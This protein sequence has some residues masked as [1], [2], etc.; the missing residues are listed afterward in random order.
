M[1]GIARTAVVS[2]TSWSYTLQA[3]DLTAMGQGPQTL[4]VTQTDAAGNTI[5][6]VIEDASRYL[7][8]GDARDGDPDQPDLLKVA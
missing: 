7:D 3:A 1:G 4:S 2:G 6:I 8:A 5:M